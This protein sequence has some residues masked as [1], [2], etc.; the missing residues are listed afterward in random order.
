MTILSTS[1]A[2]KSRGRFRLTPPDP[3]P[4]RSPFATHR[5]LVKLAHGVL[6][7]APAGAL[8][9]DLVDTLKARA[10]A[11]RLAW[12]E[13]RELTKAIESARFQRRLR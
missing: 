1:S 11:W 8:M 9:A 6:A 2:R 4:T 7:Q 12:R 10:A 5:Q 13:P 3:K